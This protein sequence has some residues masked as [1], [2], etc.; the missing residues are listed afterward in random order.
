MNLASYTAARL[1]FKYWLFSEST[2]SKFD[3]L[4]VL[5]LTPANTWQALWVDAIGNSYGWKSVLI[6]V[7]TS[8]RSIAFVFTSDGSVHYEGAYIDNVVLQGY[9]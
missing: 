2:S 1:T 8:A 9:G 7:P 4:R 5:Y 6:D 3:Y